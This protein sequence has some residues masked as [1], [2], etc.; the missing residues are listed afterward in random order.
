MDDLKPKAP[1]DSERVPEMLQQSQA[2]WE[3]YAEAECNGLY[4]QNIAG[5]I[6]GS[7]SQY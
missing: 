3:Q 7:V 2:L 1:N 5:T 6:R 4:E